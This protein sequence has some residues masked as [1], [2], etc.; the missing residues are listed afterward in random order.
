[1]NS[2]TEKKLI[3]KLK[4]GDQ[5]SFK[6]LYNY[7]ADYALRTCYYITWNRNHTADIVQETF[8]KVYK[9]IHTFNLNLSFKPWFYQILLN[10]S[11]RY[12]KK[13]SVQ[14]IPMKSEEVTHHLHEKIPSSSYT[15]YIMDDL[16]EVSESHRTVLTLKYLSGFTEKEIADM[17]DLN[18]NTVKSRLFKARRKLQG[19]IG[20]EGDE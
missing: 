15:E 2:K 4:K 7:Y 1:M 8:I 20:G 3:K 19:V 18:V 6:I 5:E 9:G 10:E 13:Q 17:L 14:A 12:M 16:A 11:K